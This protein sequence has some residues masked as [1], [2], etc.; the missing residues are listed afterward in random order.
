MNTDI[1]NAA[2]A[3]GSGRPV[4]IHPNAHKHDSRLIQKPGAQRALPRTMW[5]VI[6]GAFWLAYLYLWTPVV[7]LVMWLLGI[8]SVA[9]ELYLRKHEVDPFLMLA[10]PATAGVVVA[11]LLIWAEYNR[12]RFAAKSSE[13]RGQQREVGLEEVA[14]GLGADAQVAQAL[15][16]GR[17]SVLHMDPN[18]AVPLS[19]TAVTPTL[20]AQPFPPTAPMPRFTRQAAPGNGWM[21]VLALATIALVVGVLLLVS[22]AYRQMESSAPM[23]DVEGTPGIDRPA[24]S[25]EQLA[26]QTQAMVTRLSD[27]PIK[28][29]R[30]IA[31][32]VEKA[33]AE[34]ADAD[35]DRGRSKPRANAKPLAANAKPRPLPGFSPKP[36]YP[37]EA[38]RHREGGLVKLKVQ[39]SAD[40]RALNVA[41]VK[42]SGYRDLDRA[43]VNTVRTWRF[44]PAVRNGKAIAAVVIV[45][46]EFKPRD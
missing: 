4:K 20:P 24:L 35:A 27:E 34:R 26:E 39:V 13:R 21:V 10:L 36:P 7:T 16:A 25:A 5:G 43:A 45:P 1:R 32:A 29:A 30:A 15:N 18:H 33:E 12:W 6:T 37:L 40:G 44:A 31:A 8:R 3:G 9:S 46:V 42:R 11:L 14:R 22:Q 19:V 2:S 28:L 38:Q 41:I 17:V 23:Q